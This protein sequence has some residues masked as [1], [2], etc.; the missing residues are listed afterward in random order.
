MPPF[1]AAVIGSG[2]NGLTAA[3]RLAQAGHRVVVYE[4]DDHIGGGL[5]TAPLTLPGFRHD[6]CSSVHPMG[7][8][9]PFWR[10]LPLE[11]HGLEWL[12]PD[13]AVAHPL[14][15]GDAVLLHQ[16]V[17]E[18]A[19]GLDAVDRDRYRDVFGPLAARWHQL[20]ADAL[21]PLGVPSHPLLMASFG[22]LAFQSASGLARRLFRGNRA[23]ALFAGVAAHSVLPL[24]RTPSAAIGLMLQLAAHGVGWPLPKGGAAS[25]ATALAG[26][27]REL[28]GEIRT[29][30]HITALDQVQT[31][32]PILFDT[33]PRALAEIASEQLPPSY[34][35][36][37]KSFRYGPGAFKVD[38]ALTGP[39]PWRDPSVARAGTVHL[40]GDLNAIEA[41]ERAPW[42]GRISDQPYVLLVQHSVVD[43][44]RAPDDRQVAWAYCHVPPGHSG[45]CTDL[46]EA[47][48]ERDAPG[49][50][51]TILARHKTSA[52]ALEQLNPNYV[53]G[54]V[55]GG[56]ADWDQLFTR[57][58]WQARPYRTPDPRLYLCSASTPP[59]GGVHGMC[60][61]HAAQA[62]LS[63]HTPP[64]G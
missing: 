15:D 13:V 11:Q 17:D 18:T 51:E 10:T 47:Q 34:R 55:N 48:L 45:D 8:S 53:G 35:R 25:V 4:L 36:R 14:D 24:D 20:A 61:L 39:I 3:I 29:G 7:L 52:L 50:C 33:G 23:Q 44:T 58:T 30:C 1:T 19:D 2:P 41:S 38:W 32:G 22:A 9:S 12:Q 43:A 54:D 46:L 21:A 27:L 40:G 37:L 16:S 49:F 57:P 60:G 62:V 63:R 28:G 56:A 59:G 31:D 6:T 64:T 5:R 26:V 42:E